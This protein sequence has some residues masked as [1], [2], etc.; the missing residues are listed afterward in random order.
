M[1]EPVKDSKVIV[2]VEAYG[3]EIGR[4]SPSIETK[5]AWW[6]V[7]VTSE[8]IMYAIVYGLEDPWGALAAERIELNEL[9]LY[10]D[11]L[12]SAT[13]SYENY[14]KANRLV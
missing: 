3:H 7:Y 12:E 9:G 10:V 11:D 8:N 13:K 1:S 14:I 4:S 5:G 6:V 2:A